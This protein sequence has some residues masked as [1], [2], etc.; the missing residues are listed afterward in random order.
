MPLTQDDIEDL[1]GLLR[2][3][4]GEEVPHDEAWDVGLSLVELCRV[5]LRPA[6][7]ARESDPTVDNSQLAK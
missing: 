5:A 4:Y 2:A 3:E 1:K 6:P 7:A